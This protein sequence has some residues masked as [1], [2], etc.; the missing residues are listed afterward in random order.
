ML[1]QYFSAKRTKS[2]TSHLTPTCEKILG[3]ITQE[4]PSKIL[5]SS[6]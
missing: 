6:M 1:L 5:Q 4:T 3:E 2:E